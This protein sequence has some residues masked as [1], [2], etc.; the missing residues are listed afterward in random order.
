MKQ[1][2]LMAQKRENYYDQSVFPKDRVDNFFWPTDEEFDLIVNVILSKEYT[3]YRYGLHGE[4]GVAEE[5]EHFDNE[6]RYAWLAEHLQ[7]YVKDYS[8]PLSKEHVLESL[9]SFEMERVTSWL[10][11]QHSQS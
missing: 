9:K 6:D 7:T 4:A 2:L 5:L 1:G 3:A 10:K 8:L 11:R